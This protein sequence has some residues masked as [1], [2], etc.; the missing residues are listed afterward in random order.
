VTGEPVGPA[1]EERRL[2]SETR[3][4]FDELREDYRRFTRKVLSAVA[5]VSLFVVLALGLSAYNQW[6]QAVE[7]RNNILRSCAESNERNR[8]TIAKLDQLLTERPGALSEDDDSEREASRA[9]T[10]LL[11]NALAP[12]RDCKRLADRSVAQPGLVGPK[13]NGGTETR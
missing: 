4:R 7:R 3:K 6:R 5:V 2:D 12:V 1:T 9:G 11:I 13:T 10:V 8:E